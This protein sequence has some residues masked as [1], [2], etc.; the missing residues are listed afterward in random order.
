MG[1]SGGNSDNPNYDEVCTG[2]TRHAEVIRILFNP[3][4]ITYE[5]LLNTIE[6]I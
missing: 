3:E 5:K 1:Y 6:N 2:T 4:I